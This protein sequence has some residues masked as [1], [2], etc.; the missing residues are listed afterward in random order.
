MV[1]PIFTSVVLC[2]C[3]VDCGV[4]DTFL[5]D[6]MVFDEAGE[7]ELT[8]SGFINT[9]LS[10]KTGFLFVDLNWIMVR[11]SCI[12][13]FDCLFDCLFNSLFSSPVTK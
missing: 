7:K 13:A 10:L 5:M 4:L 11:E 8:V 12:S 1:E 6:S 9:V 3:F 2:V